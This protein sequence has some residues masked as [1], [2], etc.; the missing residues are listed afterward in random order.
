MPTR[1]E[2]ERAVERKRLEQAVEAKR[3][4]PPPR[5]PE[6]DAVNAGIMG[7]A[8]GLT[9]EWSDEIIGAVQ[10]VPLK[11]MDIAEN[12]LEGSAPYN[13]YRKAIRD[14]RRDLYKKAE[15][16]QP[17]ATLG[18][19]VLGSIVQ[20]AAMP[21]AKGAGI[22][23]TIGTAAATG[24]VQGAGASEADTVRGVAGDAAISGLMSGGLTG[25]GSALSKGVGKATDWAVN[26]K[27][28]KAIKEAA[29]KAPKKILSGILGVPE[30]YIDRYLEAPDVVNAA[31]PM[32]ELGEEVLG[33]LEALKAK[34][35]AGSEA[36]TDLI[37]ENGKINVSP[38]KDK[39]DEILSRYSGAGGVDNKA[40]K[41]AIESW[42]EQFNDIV[43]RQHIPLRD[44][45]TLVKNLDRKIKVAKESGG[46]STAENA[47]RIEL[48][49][50]I[51]RVLKEAVPEY[52]IAMTDVAADF[53]ALT[54]ASQTFGRD[55]TV[56]GALERAAR[57]TG[58]KQAA[59]REIL[60][61][62]ESRAG[63]PSIL[64]EAEDRLTQES[65]T[66][67]AER[68][69]KHTLMG[70][71]AGSAGGSVA[72]V[73]GTEALAALVGDAEAEDMMKATGGG[74]GA[75]AGAALGAY[76][77]QATKKILDAYIRNAPGV[78]AA[79]DKAS[80]GLA[81]A[82]KRG[83]DALRVAQFYALKQFPDFKDML[84]RETP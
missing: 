2:L 36:A 18:G 45:K 65:F 14:E 29:G 40:P 41:A 80:R 34:G 8:R 42:R 6:I 13:E 76:G 25:A 21:L 22:A 68:G 52:K 58:D 30:K 61:G 62:L 19:Q 54:P 15:T 78:R 12:G 28:A 71:A 17:T 16:E 1:E 44:L 83:P 4:Q 47:D 63:G 60:G 84:E 73:L 69:S 55:K 74:I 24:A 46:F 11:A 31:R 70:Y 5:G 27:V 67:N 32:G 38:I 56:A 23:K 51:D 37:P 50:E 79:I 57:N 59:Q 9:G 82:A 64:K 7:T 66:K 3:M 72:G 81:E 48:R 35:I 26:T 39:L 43:S 20:G 77:P 10:A 33:K 49:S 75:I 53:S